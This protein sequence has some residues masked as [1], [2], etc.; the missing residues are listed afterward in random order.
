MLTIQNKLAG[1]T[2]DVVALLKDTALSAEP[3]VRAGEV[4]RKTELL[5]PVIGAFSA[6]K[7]SLINGFLREDILAV[8]LTPETELATEIR[9]GT[10]PHLLAI[11]ADGSSERMELAD[12]SSLK[13]R[14]GEFSYLQLYLNNPH[15]Q[16]FSDLVLVDMPGFDSSLENHNKA[17]ARYLPRGVHFIVVT[18][19]ED[20]NITRSML[21]QLGEMET[22]GHNFTYVLNKIN[23][24]TDDDI[25]KV[26]ELVAE[27]IQQPVIRIGWDRHDRMREIL[28][29]L[30]PESIFRDL[31]VDQL[32]DL[33][34][35]LLSQIGL[36][37][38]A[39]N[40]DQKKNEQMRT[41]MEKAIRNL[42]E[43]RDDLISKLQT[44]TLDRVVADCLSKVEIE[45]ESAGEELITAGV[46]GNQLAFSR[47]V[48][49][50]VRATLTHVIKQKLSAISQSVVTELSES[51]RDLSQSLG[52]FTQEPDWLEQ[53]VK[54]INR[55][56]EKTGEMF[57]LDSTSKCNTLHLFILV[58]PCRFPI[59]I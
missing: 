9:Y 8:G 23:L 52:D 47:I 35:T 37:V 22:Y 16:Q 29:A 31:F 28:C 7:S 54:Q 50:I 19:I 24:R 11:R 33:T 51:I 45:L 10:Q 21:R 20:G 34:H 56:L 42:L 55:G 53:M 57:S 43:K 44:Q 4:I 27:Q 58:L 15:L 59:I 41:D 25:N 14:V 49:D 18:N 40:K 36:A 46:S 3:F 32:K 6:G 2:D 17:I 5:V 39:L 26:A 13:S 30:Q 38:T 1:Y 12:M 48:T